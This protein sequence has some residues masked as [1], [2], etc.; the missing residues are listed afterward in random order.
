[1]QEMQKKNA[2]L[3]T[4]VPCLGS[5]SLLD[6]LSQREKCLVYHKNA[7]TIVIKSRPHNHS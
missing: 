5:T 2:I 1:M 4:C 7:L 6:L 3:S